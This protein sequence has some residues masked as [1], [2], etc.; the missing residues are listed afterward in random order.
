VLSI[1]SGC[2]FA[3]SMAR[4]SLPAAKPS[5]RFSRPASLCGTSAP[6]LPTTGIEQNG[7]GTRRERIGDRQIGKRIAVEVSHC[8]KGS[9]AAGS[10]R[11]GVP[12]SAIPLTQQ[13]AHGAR[14]Y[15]GHGEIRNAVVVEVP[16]RHGLGS[17]VDGVALGSLKSAVA[18]A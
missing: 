2:A 15:A 12:K 17:R 16:N 4:P 3:S 18:V 9:T 10:I 6:S 8:H 14:V 11:L 13:D 7:N 1:S 5:A